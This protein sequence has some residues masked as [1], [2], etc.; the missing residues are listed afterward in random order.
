MYEHILRCANKPAAPLLFP[1]YVSKRHR[2]VRESHHYLKVPHA[3]APCMHTFIPP[4]TFDVLF[5]NTVLP[6]MLTLELNSSVARLREELELSK[7]G[8]EVF[9]PGDDGASDH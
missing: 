1:S 7:L 3:H 8:D 2:L 5:M 4:R 9:T 6:D